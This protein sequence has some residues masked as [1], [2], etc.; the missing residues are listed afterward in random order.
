MRET[1]RR[2][3]SVGLGFEGVVRSKQPKVLITPSRPRGARVLVKPDSLVLNFYPRSW[4]GYGRGLVEAWETTEQTTRFSVWEP[5]ARSSA[6]WS[7]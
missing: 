4:F 6:Q 1:E 5:L 3:R 2:L 7:C